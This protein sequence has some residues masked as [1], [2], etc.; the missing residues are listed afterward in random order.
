MSENPVYVI[1]LAGG[2]GIRL[3]PISRK[4][5]PKQ[6][7]D[8]T[9]NGRSLLQETVRRALELTGSI[10]QVLVLT[11]SAHANLVRE[12]VADLPA[13]N[14]LI[15]P[16]GRNTAASLGLAAI[17]LSQKSGTAGSSSAVM[18][19]LPV[20]HM[21]KDEKP[22][23]TAV[24]TAIEVA[25][26]MNSLVAIGLQPTY[27]ATGFGYQHLGDKKD[28]DQPLAV[29]AIQDFVE[30]PSIKVAQT[31]LESGQYLWNTGTYAWKVD[32]F[33]AALEE[34]APQLFSGLKS[35]GTPLDAAILAKVYPAFA[36][37]SVDY[38]V[39]EKAKNVLT[40]QANFE[41][42][43][44][45]SLGSLSEIRQPDAQGNVSIGQVLIQDSQDNIVFSDHG[46]VTLLGVKDLIVIRAGEIVLVC[47]KDK[48]QE[49]KNVVAEL[50]RRGQEA[51]L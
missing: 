48:T 28:L 5:C 11:Q 2:Q 42:I 50:T 25:G 19:T 32:V 45:G 36:N 9:G 6:F 4:A 44:V 47:P 29:H 31:Y 49:I 33:L 23:I 35:L 3:W 15:E 14:L 26:R 7:L 37:I 12:Q 43:D 20:D 10:R 24:R 17:T 39:M 18:L 13:E 41:R 34:H 16:V 30:K 46:L 22:W 38:A 40:V 8:L 21:F 27:P 1:I 51:Y